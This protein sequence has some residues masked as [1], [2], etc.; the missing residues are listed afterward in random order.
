MDV[1]ARTKNDDDKD[2]QD[3]M[4]KLEAEIERSDKDKKNRLL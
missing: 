2:D 4:N 1:K 3:D